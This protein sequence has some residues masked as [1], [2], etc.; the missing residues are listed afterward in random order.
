MPLQDTSLSL[1]FCLQQSIYQD[2]F[3]RDLSPLHSFAMPLINELDLEEGDICL[4]L[5]L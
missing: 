3:Y 1:D 5:I 2:I 4:C